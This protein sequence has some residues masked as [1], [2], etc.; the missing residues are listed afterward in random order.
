MSSAPHAATAVAEGSAASVAA[1]PL[2]EQRQAFGR[3]L[4]A[5]VAHGIRTPLHSLLGFLELLSMGELDDGQ[6][7]TLDQ[8]L[9]GADELLAASDRLWSLVRLVTDDRP[10]RR[11]SFALRALVADVATGAGAG[12]PVQVTIGA[13]VPSQVTGD[14]AYL[15][16]VLSELVDNGLAYGAGPVTI[17]VAAEG[18][19]DPTGT[20]L[21]FSVLDSG[22]GLPAAMLPYVDGPDATFPAGGP[23]PVG[24][25]GFGLFLARHLVLKIGGSL[26]A[27][28]RPGG[29]TRMSVHLRLLPA[30]AP[31]A[32]TAAPH[33]AA[34]PT[35]GGH[36]AGAAAAHAAGPDA[37]TS[38]SG[39]PGQLRVLLVEDNSVN[40]ILAQRQVDRLGHLLVAVGG[41]L[42]GVERALAEEYD[43]VLM[44]RHLPDLDGVEATRR[45]RATELARADGRRTPIVA[46]TADVRPG[47][48][49]ECLAAGMDGFLTKPVELEQ[50]RAALAAATAP[51]AATSPAAE[52]DLCVDPGMIQSLTDQLDGDL[53]TV[54]ELI[55]T[56]LDELPG[57]RL[58][59]QSA[60]RR[61]T[62]RQLIAAAE[63]LRAS[64]V[65]VG[66]ARLARVCADIERAVRTGQDDDRQ[67]L[68]DRLLDA[69]DQT[70]AALSGHA[71]PA[72]HWLTPP[73]GTR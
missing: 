15:H 40:R 44:D 6:R 63:S 36:P 60:V 13:G 64:S 5:A 51:A 59:L 9:G 12:A 16:Q 18:V 57:W 71:T 73:S 7:D 11:D 25:G 8:A 22:P 48:R 46:V 19:A 3:V 41:G 38:A 49:E 29:G 14:S 52:V 70:T 58:R 45:I 2:G 24:L 66:A 35:R 72:S 27:V 43:V 21:R 50:L 68:L 47:H 28:P 39:P 42:A 4:S 67:A 62:P 65:T 56:Y 61:G 53:T 31:E 20:P 30:S 33:D 26:V 54:S 1:I 10:A 69:C 34:R 17:D 23:G 37:R 55:R 32:R